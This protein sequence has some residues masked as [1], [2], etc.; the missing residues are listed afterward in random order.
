MKK[1]KEAW[2]K[3]RAEGQR[4]RRELQK[5]EHKEQETLKSLSQ[6]LIDQEDKN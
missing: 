4:G 6:K 3:W 1:E 2:R 5:Y